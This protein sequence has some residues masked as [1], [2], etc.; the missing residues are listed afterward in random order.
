[1]LWIAAVGAVSGQPAKHA[2][3]SDSPAAEQSD[4]ERLRHLEETVQLLLIQNAEL[5]EQ[6]DKLREERIPMTKEP[7]TSSD[8]SNESQA[9]SATETKPA[10]STA[11]AFSWKNGLRFESA[12]GKTLKGKLGGRIQYDAATFDQ[13]TA[14]KDTAGDATTASEL[15][16]VRLYTSGDLNLGVPVFYKS[17]VDFAGSDFKFAD[18]YVGIKDIPYLGVLQ[19]GQRYEPFSLE[20][21]TSGNYV[22]FLERAA[23][24][25]AFSPGRNVGA[26]FRNDLLNGRATWAF[27]LFADDKNDRGDGDGFDSNTHVTGRITALPWYDESSSGSRYWHLGAGGSLMNPENDTVRFRSRPEAHLAPRYVDTMGFSGTDVYLSNVESALT[28]GSLSL[29]A[30]YFRTWVNAVTGPDPSFDGF[31]IF[32]SWFLTGEHRP[33]VQS[34]GIIGRE[35]PLKNFSFGSSGLGALEFALRYTRLDLDDESIAGGQMADYSAGLNWYL[36]PNARAMLNYILT[37]LDRGSEDGT[38]HSVQA[39]FQVD[40]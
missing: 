25:E 2:V 19:L 5:K 32:G 22:T 37:D 9:P 39:R 3:G 20:Q 21:L 18:V 15:R 7:G 29:Q 23:P 10:S 27:G 4:S 6:V 35:K 1:M 16:R 34:E 28:F 17:Q 12:D 36:N 24:I 30:E 33:Y 40:F 8:T 26:L 31:Y 13:D 38:G 11:V 14:V